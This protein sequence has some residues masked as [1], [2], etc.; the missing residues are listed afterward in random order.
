MEANVR[1]AG[2]QASAMALVRG[3]MAGTTAKMDL[4]PAE[5]PV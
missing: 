1:L 2:E 5:E 4:K 3:R